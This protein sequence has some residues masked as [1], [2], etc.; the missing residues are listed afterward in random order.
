[1]MSNNSSLGSDQKILLFGKWSF[2]DVRVEDPGL[3]RYIC[4]KPVFIPHSGG[5]HAKERFKKSTISIVE[6]LVNNLMHKPGTKN[7]GKNSGKKILAINIVKH[8]F[9]I[10]YLK[11]GRNPIQILVKAIENA[12][13]REETTRIA[14][15]GV[16]YHVSVDVAP[17]R[18]LDLALRHIAQG[19]RAMAFRNPKP[20]EECLADELILAATNDPKSYAI[21]KKDEIERI[22]FASR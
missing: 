7:P 1:M 11:T 8:A 15:G 18:R 13:P 21:Q 12:G 20:I 9:D 2:S 6:R 14:Y 10:I 22:A 19:A 3:A 17:Q 4:L 16:V 5:R